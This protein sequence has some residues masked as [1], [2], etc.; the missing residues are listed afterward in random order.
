MFIVGVKNVGSIKM[1]IN[2]LVVLTICVAANMISSVNNKTSFT[3][4][5]GEVCEG[6]TE[7]SSAY[8]QIVVFCHLD[9]WLRFANIDLKKA[10][11]D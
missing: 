5:V 6:C 11:N 4:F 1:Y 8:N 2:A 7:Q 10:V 9:L 3:G